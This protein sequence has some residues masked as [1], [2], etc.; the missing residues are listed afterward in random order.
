MVDSTDSITVE[1]R[2]R[3]ELRAIF[4]VACDS[5]LPFFEPDNQWQ[6]QSHEHWALR[7]LKEQFPLL[8]AADSYLVIQ[9]VKRMIASGAQRM[10]IPTKA[11]LPARSVQ[12]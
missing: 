9:T 10:P 7:A 6:G 12:T 11:A 3:L 1:R 2:V 8:G 5:I 4:P